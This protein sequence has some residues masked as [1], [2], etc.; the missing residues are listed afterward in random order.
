MKRRS[1]RS[2]HGV[3]VS[4]LQS[5]SGTMSRVCW[6]WGARALRRFILVP[7]PPH[8]STSR[9]V[10]HNCPHAQNSPAYNERLAGKER[11]S[12]HH[13]YIILMQNECNS[14]PVDS[15]KYGNN[16]NIQY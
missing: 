10:S 8:T 7:L 2:V 3:T 16:S 14:Q 1:A 11:L 9:D 13:N 4:A 6:G 15:T 12:I 5:V